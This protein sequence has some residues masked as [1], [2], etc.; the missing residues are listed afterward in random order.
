MATDR[1]VNYTTIN[2][3]PLVVAEACVLIGE[4]FARLVMGKSTRIDLR[5][6]IEFSIRTVRK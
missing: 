3:S 2:Q 6:R 1:R 5:R 4:M